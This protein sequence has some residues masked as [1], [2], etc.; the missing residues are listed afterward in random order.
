MQC[1]N[2]LEIPL[3]AMDTTFYEEQYLSLTAIDIMKYL[4]PLVEE[5]R[6]Q[7]GVFT[8]LWHNNYFADY[9]YPGWGEL[10]RNICN[11]CIRSNGSSYTGKELVGILT[12]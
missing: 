5:I 12:E 1:L 9:I 4:S 10:Y 7:E 3:I 8:L 2:V 11:Y 6:L